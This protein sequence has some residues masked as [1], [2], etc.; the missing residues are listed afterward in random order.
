MDNHLIDPVGMD[1]LRQG[2]SL[3]AQKILQGGIGPHLR[4]NTV[5]TYDQWK[6]I[7]TAV[8]TAARQRMVITAD[9]MGRGLTED[10]GSD[11][12]GVTVMVSQKASG[13]AAAQMD[14]N[15]DTETRKDRIELGT[16]YL[17]IPIVHS[18]FWL[19]VREL[20]ASQRN[21]IGLDTT[22]AEECAQVIMEKIETNF[23]S[24][25]SSFKFGSGTIY[26]IEDFP[27]V[28]TTSL[29]ANW[30]A[31]GA[32]PV[33]DVVAL[34]QAAI[35][36][37]HYGPYMVYVPTAYETQLDTDYV[38]GYPKSVRTRILEIDKIEGIKVVDKMSAN[39]V[40]LVQMQKNT[41][42]AVTGWGGALQTVEWESQGGMRVHYK[43]MGI[44]VPQIRSDYNDR[45]GIVIGT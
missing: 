45:C 17:P 8:V 21:G 1:D 44:I 13:I 41:I 15:A 40:A 24:G 36:D 23:T 19:N 7:D 31:S 32:D 25:T 2:T 11:P 39:H 42:R 34:K 20:K 3:M 37:R 35:N 5:L 9:V 33:A 29:T 4:E 38:S 27:N 14:M 12:L 43:V 10:L 16:D 6:K 26:G 30:D 18:G 28:S 22:L